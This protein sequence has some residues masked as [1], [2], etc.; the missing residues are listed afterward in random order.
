MVIAP[1][2][3]G[4]WRAALGRKDVWLLFRGASEAAKS[5]FV[6]IKELIPDPLPTP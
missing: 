4:M 2:V 5:T 6:V 3:S 1:I